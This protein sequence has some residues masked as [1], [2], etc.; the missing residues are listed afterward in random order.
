[1]FEDYINDEIR[2]PLNEQISK[3]NKNDRMKELKGM[4]WLHK[5]NGTS[6][7]EMIKDL[8][9]Y[10]FTYDELVEIGLIKKGE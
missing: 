9:A 10:T 3:M 7:D 4:L 8:M 6:K 5:Q 1:M 2:Y